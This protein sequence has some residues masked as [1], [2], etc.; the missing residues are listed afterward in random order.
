MQPTT[1][2]FH[3]GDAVRLSL[4]TYQGSRGVFLRLRDD[5]RWAEIRETDGAVRSH[6]VAWVILAVPET[7]IVGKDKTLSV[8]IL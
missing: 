2:E 6:P 7:A 3:E 1:T 8:G 4:G 5:I